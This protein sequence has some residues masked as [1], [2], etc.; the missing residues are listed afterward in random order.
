MF[1]ANYFRTAAIDSL[2]DT[3][4]AATLTAARWGVIGWEWY[5]ES[6]FSAKAKARYEW[7]GQIL[8][9]LAMACYIAGK[10]SRELVAQTEL[11]HWVDAQVA[12]ALPQPQ[13]L[14]PAAPSQR[15]LAPAPEPVDPLPAND[16]F[17]NTNKMVEADPFC[18]T[19]NPLPVSV[20]PVP[21]LAQMTLAQLRKRAIAHNASL[22]AGHPNRIARAARLTKAEALRA[23][24]G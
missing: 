14:I 8:A 9:C 21:A 12:E 17:V 4:I 18:P 13:R 2:G 5:T 20:D 24:A 19:V 23:L 3:A 16:H 11:Q 15:L 1:H 6:F 22:P 7:V 10:A